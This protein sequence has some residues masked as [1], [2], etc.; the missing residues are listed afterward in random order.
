MKNQ[1]HMISVT[2][3]F[4]RSGYVN[5]SD[6]KMY[7]LSERGFN[8]SAT[9]KTAYNIY[10]LW[11]EVVGINTLGN[12]SRWNGFPLRCLYLGSV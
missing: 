12:S 3:A 7:H 1:V 10:I 4:V 9:S 5:V 8:W 11:I 6:G 2:L